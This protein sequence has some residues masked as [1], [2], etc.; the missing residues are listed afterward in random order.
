MIAFQNAARGIVCMCLTA[1]LLAC[2]GGPPPRDE[3]DLAL[4][5]AARLANAG[6]LEGAAAIY[7]QQAGFNPSPERENLKLRALETVLTLE[8]REIAKN[9]LE[10]LDEA[11]LV[12]SLLVRKRIAEAE[13][14]MLFDRP[15]LAVKALPT[16]LD[17]L[18]P[19]LISVV[20]RVRARALLASGE[21]FASVKTRMGLADRLIDPQEKQNNYRHI[22]ESLAL[23]EPQQLVH[24]GKQT[25]DGGLKGWIELAYISK[26]APVELAGLQQQLNDWRQRFRQHPADPRFIAR[27][28]EDW[29][30]LQVRPEKI[31][32][33]LPFS[34]SYAK[35][36]QAIITGIIAAYYSAP[37]P[38]ES[39]TLDFYD[40]GAPQADIKEIYTRAM[41]N[42][43]DMILGPL[44]K[45]NVAALATMGELPVPVLSL[46]YLDETASPPSNLFQFG[47]LPE[48]EARQV[49]ERAALDGYNHA[50]VFVPEGTWG[51]RLLE[52]FRERFETL[53]GT[54]LAT[55]RYLPNE[56]DYSYAIKRALLIDESEKRYKAIKAIANREVQFKPRRRQDAEFIFIAASPR[57]ARLL[58]PQLK[59]HYAADLPVYATSH[60][61]SGIENVSSDK[62]LDGIRFCDIPWVL[63]EENPE[64]EL[65]TSLGALFPQT[66][67]QLP[68]LVALGF[69]A[70]KLV[71]YVKFLAARPYERYQGLTGNLSVDDAQRVHRQ[72]N[73]AHFVR[74]SPQSM[75]DALLPVSELGPQR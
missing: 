18:D 9:Y 51:T 64:P 28:L 42:G 2:A 52:S 23:A 49:A 48:D 37:N 20:Q 45:N 38:S 24:W 44:N 60:V 59:F 31:A 69:D 10:Q 46:N 62:D 15:S 39:S 6:N 68:R 22:W 13:L 19:K 21:I 29:R 34:G 11:K 70:Y 8:T 71:P 66:N 67:K 3:S 43:A 25:M 36:A 35:V 14:A 33:L 61:Y 73:W 50:I 58:R 5:R 57:Q 74:G 47:L 40:L 65:N 72:L 55:E 1:V 30:T 56:A 12:G 4:E 41:N 63:T 54:S 75:S 17:G 16:S 26:T 32:V 7:W 53:G 27:V